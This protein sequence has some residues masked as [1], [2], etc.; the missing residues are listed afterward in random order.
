MT[1]KGITAAVLFLCALASP[2]EARESVV[3]T[4]AAEPQGVRPVRKNCRGLSGGWRG[5]M[6][7][8]TI[9][10][11]RFTGSIYEKGGRCLGRFL[12]RFGSGSVTQH[13]DVTISGDNI[14]LKGTRA[15]SASYNLDFLKGRDTA[16]RS[17]FTGTWSDSQGARGTLS[18]SRQ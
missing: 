6:R 18:F 13:F 3:D 17:A 10:D 8:R 12:V 9:T 4:P 14:E 11:H 2:V 7:G 15:S 16:S 1:S 5:V